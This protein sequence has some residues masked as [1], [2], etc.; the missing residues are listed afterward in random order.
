VRSGKAGPGK[1]KVKMVLT[2]E[3]TGLNHVVAGDID[4]P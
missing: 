2:A 3:G 4:L 1:L